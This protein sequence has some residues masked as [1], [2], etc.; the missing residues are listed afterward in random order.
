[1]ENLSFFID[2]Y[3]LFR[4]ADEELE[5][6]KRDAAAGDVEACYKLGRY[7]YCV[8]PEEDSVAQAERLYVESSAGG[9]DDADIAIA[10]MWD[11]GNMG[12]VDR[13]KSRALIRRGLEK[14]NEF[15]ADLYLRRI[16]YGTYGYKQDFKTAKQTITALMESNNPRWYYLMGCLLQEEGDLKAACKWYERALEAGVISAYSDVAIAKTHDND[17]NVVDF[18]QYVELLLAGCDAGDAFSMYSIAVTMLSMYDSGQG[19][20]K[21]REYILSSLKQAVALGCGAAAACLGE[22]YREGLCDVPKDLEAAFGWYAKGAILESGDCYEALFDMICA[23]ESHCGI[24][25]RDNC[26]LNGARRG[27]ERMK[28]QAVIAYKEGRL[29]AFASEIELYYL[30]I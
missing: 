29:T 14:N 13:A 7:H 21:E 28:Q 20:T 4:L 25:F 12:I 8:R 24:E 2:Y 9:V 10:V 6:I 11:H 16:I 1:M 19:G 23:G 22:I 27:N 30:S 17:Y 15:A 18:E 5:Q 26:A 3:N